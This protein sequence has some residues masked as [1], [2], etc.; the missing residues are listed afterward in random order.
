MPGV[1]KEEYVALAAFRRALR[2]FLRFAEEGA[3]S[4]GITPQQHQVLLAVAGQPDRDWATVGELATALQ[5]RHHAIVGLL[6]R[7]QAADLIV[8]TQAPDDRRVVRVSLTPKG[9][10][11]LAHLTERNLGSLRTLGSLVEA[12]EAAGKDQVGS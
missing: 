3:R 2:R 9:E 12:L 10:D 7:C 5:L 6:D 1:G 11:L 8:R 4:V